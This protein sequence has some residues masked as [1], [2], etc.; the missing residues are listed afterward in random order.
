M[1]E[2]NLADF[3][4]A[5]T[6]AILESWIEFARESAP[7]QPADLA[8][9][10][11]RAEG[12]LQTIVA[13]L[14]HAQTPVEQT[15]KSKGRSPRCTMISHATLHGAERALAG[16]SI[17]QEIAEFRALRANVLRLWSTTSAPPLP[18]VGEELVRFNESVDQALAESVERFMAEQDR[19]SRRYDSL[20]SASP[21]PHCLL[22]LDGTFVFANRALADLLGVPLSEIG[23]K[24]LAEL[25]PPGNPL[26]QPFDQVTTHHEPFRGDIAYTNASGRS[27]VY[28]FILAPVTDAEGAVESF[29]GTAR[30]ITARKQLE[31]DLIREKAIL[32]S[33]IESAP[34][35]FFMI[36]QHYRLIRWNKLL[37]QEIGLSDT[38]LRNSSLITN[39]A[40][41][42]RAMAVAKLLT[43]F[44]TGRACMEVHVPTRDRGV[45]LYHKTARRFMVGDAPYLAGFC[46]DVT[47]RKRSEE[48]LFKE[49]AFSDAL[50]ESVPGAFYVIDSEGN[51]CRWNS[52]LTRLT[53][54]T[55]GQLNN[56]PMLLTIQEEDRPLAATTLRG[57]FDSGY[58]QAELHVITHDRGIRL[59]FMT[60]RRFVVDNT[61]FLVGVGTDTTEWLAK[62]K[63]LEHEAWIDGLTQVAN[64]DHFLQTAKMEFARCRR[65]DH[66]L[67]LWML[68]IDHFKTI[69]DSFGHHAGDIALQ[70]VVSIIQR[71][72]RDWD[73]TGRMGGEEFA[74]M[75]PE[76]ETKQAVLIAERLRQ[77][78]A[79][80]QIPLDGGNS[81]HITVSIGIATADD[82]D[83]ELE[84]LLGR[85]DEALYE[86][87][88]TGRDKVS[89]A[90]RLLPA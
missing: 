58:A 85:A 16:F 15:A 37:S 72:L 81:A 21:E 45:R 65:Y 14:S 86:A 50:I 23:G 22:D 48:A 56:C 18:A 7:N 8:L 13:D 35:R 46:V 52:Y 44:A 77:A 1:N 70:S 26:Q 71:V 40:E 9:L 63:A 64:R 83:T 34:G 12:I 62:L 24:K 80:N 53:G 84:S 79:A 25:V 41:E 47:D 6:V 90:R 88:Q 2:P 55:N 5:N 29:A 76:T 51:Y 69:N 61:P 3:I 10:H 31:D 38:Q 89:L 4:R 28:E 42:D 39:I 82:G 17:E 54:M 67:S 30:E 74:V 43:A 11:D 78:V 57:A 59:Y 49:K 87:K 75:L 68:D 27:V 73:L 66:P 19:H 20:L 33:I 36:D 60:A 32:D